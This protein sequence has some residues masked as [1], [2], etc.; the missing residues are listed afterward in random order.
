MST[1]QT[2]INALLRIADWIDE[3]PNAD[4]DEATIF[5]H[6]AA[7][8]DAVSLIQ[9]Q[10]DVIFELQFGKVSFKGA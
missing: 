2:T 4:M 1:S 7:I 3:L 5:V 6:S 8:R 9:K 10:R